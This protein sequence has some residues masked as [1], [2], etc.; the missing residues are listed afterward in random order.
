MLAIGQLYLKHRMK[1][2]RKQKN[3]ELHGNSFKM[4]NLSL[5]TG[6]RSMTAKSHPSSYIVCWILGRSF[7][8]LQSMLHRLHFI[9]PPLHMFPQ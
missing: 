3:M 9:W 7:F 6:I 5:L 2:K 4:N 8:T 1:Q